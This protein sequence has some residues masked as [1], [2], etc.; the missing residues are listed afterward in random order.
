MSLETAKI[1]FEAFAELHAAE[2]WNQMKSI[3]FTRYGAIGGGSLSGCI[4]AFFRLPDE[5]KATACI[6]AWRG[7]IEGRDGVLSPD[8]IEIIARR[9]DFPTLSA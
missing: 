1:D 7:A 8:D 3:K 9:A 6:S 4:H 2:N 5:D